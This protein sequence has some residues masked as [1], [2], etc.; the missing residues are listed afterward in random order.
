MRGSRTLRDLMDFLHFHKPDLVFL[1]E[2]KMTSCQMGNLKS[3]VGM[4]GI[5]CVPRDEEGGGFSGGLCLMWRRNISVSFLSSSFF[6]I[7]TMVTWEDGYVCRVT[8]FYGEPVATRRHLSWHL[9]RQLAS[10]R[11]GPWLCCGDCNEILVIHEK[12]GDAIRPQRLIDNFR[13]A[14]HDCGL[15]DFDF[16]GYQFTWDNRR[17]GTANVKERIDRGF[18]NL[19]LIQK[20]GGFLCHHLVTMASDHC[21]ILIENV[22]PMSEGGGV[23][24]R[25]RRFIFEEMWSKEEECG[26]I[27]NQT[28]RRGGHLDIRFMLGPLGVWA[29][30][31]WY[32]I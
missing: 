25:P 29:E 24:R 31:C 18:G 6:Y 28:W 8:G 11:E 30:I 21:P 20:W 4:E 14:L 12:T 3:S 17:I 2:T 1:L 9:L 10:E 13:S 15:Y 32:Q 23:G 7:D 22:A 26:Q 16:T 27:I 19:E 5:L